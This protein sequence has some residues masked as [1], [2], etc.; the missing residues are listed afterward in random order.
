MLSKHQQQ[1]QTTLEAILVANDALIGF[2]ITQSDLANKVDKKTILAADSIKRDG[3]IILR[4]IKNDQSF[5]RYLASTQA[6][7]AVGQLNDNIS[8]LAKAKGQ[9]ETRAGEVTRRISEIFLNLRREFPPKARKKNSPAKSSS[10]TKIINTKI[11]SSTNN[12]VANPVR[13]TTPAPSL[14][15]TTAV[16]KQA[17]ILS[18]LMQFLQSLVSIFSFFRK[19]PKQAESIKTGKAN[20]VPPCQP[21]NTTSVSPPTA[22][23]VATEKMNQRRTQEAEKKNKISNK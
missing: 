13:P 18:V 6:E 11:S 8:A 20:F 22:W 19:K 2:G 9:G 5:K 16:S 17:G 12:K 3:S 10:S 15:A 23:K 4:K 14:P 7:Q 1:H 21:K